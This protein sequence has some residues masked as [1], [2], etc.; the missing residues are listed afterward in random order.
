M[1]LAVGA[2]RAAHAGLAAVLLVVLAFLGC[3]SGDVASAPQSIRVKSS[4]GPLTLE[5]VAEGLVTPWSV[6]FLPDGRYLVTERPGRMRVIGAD[7]RLSEPIAGVPK[8]HARGQGGLLDVALAPDFERSGTIYFSYAEPVDDKARTAVM[9]ARLDLDALRLDAT[10]RIFAQHPAHPGNNHWGSRLAFDREG[11]LFVTL[12]DR[13]DLRDQALDLSSH[14]GKIVRLRPDGS[15]PS[16]NPFTTRKGALPEIWSYGHRNIQG[17]TFHPETGELWIHEHGPRGGDEVNRILPGRNYGWPRIT[18]GREY[19]SGARIG[20]GTS[21]A[22]VEPPL[23]QWTPSIA[24]SGMTFVAGERWGEWH[25]D[26]LTGSLAG[27]RLVRLEGDANGM[28]EAERLL[29]EIRA[30]IR[31]VRQGPDGAIYLLDE[32]RGRLLRLLPPGQ[33]G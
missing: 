10:E 13:Y 11:M 5:T 17:A 33:P 1:R 23:W 3:R 29:D 18:Y 24:P 28:R 2:R 7:G 22:D 8:V 14:I 31:D 21:A 9:R 32:S 27:E 6:A 16:D 20:E 19:A 30:R 15:V 4:L 25:G 26:L 12:G